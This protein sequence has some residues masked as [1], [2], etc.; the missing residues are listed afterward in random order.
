MADAVQLRGGAGQIVAT[1]GKQL[2]VQSGFPFPWSD[3]VLVPRLAVFGHRD[4]AFDGAVRI[5]GVK[6]IGVLECGPW[7]FWLAI[8]QD[9]R[10]PKK[11]RR[12]PGICGTKPPASSIRM[13]PPF[14]RP[15]YLSCPPRMTGRNAGH[16]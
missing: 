1:D 16:H 8:D 13:M 7:T 10:F 3:D 6:N 2:L 4:V 14:W 9:S 5:G 12:S 15:R 11:G